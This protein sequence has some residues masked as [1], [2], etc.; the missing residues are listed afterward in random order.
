M[1][2]RKERSV[3]W[4]VSTH[5]LT[6]GFAMPF[7][8]SLVAGAVVLSIQPSPLVSFLILLA[9][10][11]VGYIG[12]VFYSLSYIRK[13]AIVPNPAACIKPSILTFTALALI[14]LTVNL[15]RILGQGGTSIHSI[16]IVL[17]LVVFYTLICIAFAKYTRD[18]FS[19]MPPGTMDA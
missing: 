15:L 11:A 16:V 1:P 14:G 2:K 9:A 5:V 10:Q 8:A 13:V 12:G 4:V 6:T 18:G 3:F 7:V 17:A 19:Q